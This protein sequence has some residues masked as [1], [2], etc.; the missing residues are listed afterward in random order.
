MFKFINKY[1][2]H[3]CNQNNLEQ[4]N[5]IRFKFDQGWKSQRFIMIH[6]KPIRFFLI[7]QIGKQ[8]KNAGILSAANQFELISLWKKAS[9]I[10]WKWIISRVSGPI[11]IWLALPQYARMLIKTLLL[12]SITIFVS[13]FT[14]YFSESQT[15]NVNCIESHLNQFEIIFEWI[16]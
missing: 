8:Y 3:M 13:W 11:V 7:L 5:K 2:R 15:E 9:R 1:V 12:V 10:S 14:N 16:K 4:I 6:F